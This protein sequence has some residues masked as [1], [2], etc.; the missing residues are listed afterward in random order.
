MNSLLFDNQMLPI[1]RR[2]KDDKVHNIQ[3]VTM[4]CCPQLCSYFH[5]VISQKNQNLV[6]K[7][8]VL[9]YIIKNQI[10]QGDAKNFICLLGLPVLKI[11]RQS[12]KNI[13]LITLSCLSV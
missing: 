1:T 10:S 11:L 5:N 6:T 2:I 13:F 9:G 7:F 3:D 4:F 8:I 12:F